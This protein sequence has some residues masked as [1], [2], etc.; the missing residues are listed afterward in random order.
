MQGEE[1]L[2]GSY[3]VVQALAPAAPRS[4]R[5]FLEKPANGGATPTPTTSA[6]A[7]VPTEP[8]QPRTDVANADKIFVI[9]VSGLVGT[10]LNSEVRKSTVEY[11]VPFSRLSQEMA[12]I[13]KTGV[14]ILS[15][16]EA[17]VLGTV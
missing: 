10:S 1:E 11:K 14:K 7:A 15:V 6:T 2:A 5:L 12:R 8:K 3:R 16:E 13:T 17:D 9:K 4:W